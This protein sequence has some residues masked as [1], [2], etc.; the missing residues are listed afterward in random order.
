[1][2]IITIKFL[3]KTNFKYITLQLKFLIL[4]S[5]LGGVY[6]ISTQV[7]FTSIGISILQ[8]RAMFNF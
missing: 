1:M 2:Q 8:A 4:M 6:S 7:S 3:Q 5:T